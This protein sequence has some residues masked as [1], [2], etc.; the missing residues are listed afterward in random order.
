MPLSDLERRAVARWKPPADTLFNLMLARLV[1]GISRFVTTRM[2]SLTIEGMERFTS[3]QDRGSGL[4]TFSNHVSLFD[5]PLLISNLTIGPYGDIRWVAA[6]SLN[7]FG[8]PSK[9]FIFSRGKAVPIVRG[10]GLAQTGFTFLRDRLREGAWVHIFPEGGRT[11]DPRA[12]LTTPF[13]PGIGRLIAESHPIGLPFYHYGMHRILPLGAKAP[14]RGHTVRLV[15][16]DAIDYGEPAVREIA[17]HQLAA[18]GGP[19]LW[20]A[21]SEHA[22]RALQALESAVHPEAP[23][24]TRLRRARTR[25]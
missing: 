12:L 18:A 9:A 11:R 4:L 7:F 1:V 19:A 16:G 2:N 5:D 10:G 23:R 13:R 22:C 17:G 6:D 15:F 3:L 24:R 20:E 25:A 14:R 8:S 21:L